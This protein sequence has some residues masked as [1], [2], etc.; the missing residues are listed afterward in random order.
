MSAA[1]HTSIPAVVRV[2]RL[3]RLAGW[4]IGVPLH[5]AL[6]HW[7]VVAELA[8]HDACRDQTD[9]ESTST[10][11]LLHRDLAVPLKIRHVQG[12]RL[13]N[14]APYRIS[15]S[16]LTWVHGDRGTVVEKHRERQPQRQR[17]VH[18]GGPVRQYERDAEADQRG[19]EYADCCNT[20][21]PVESHSGV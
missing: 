17:H 1:Q 18:P 16:L 14:V 19:N 7:P 2:R 11:A 5:G 9:R 10:C 13:D 15:T 20:C 4:A 8:P 3:G 6:L 12:E 21:P